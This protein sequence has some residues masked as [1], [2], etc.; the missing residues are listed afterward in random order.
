MGGLDTGPWTSSCSAEG[1]YL[2]V[3]FQKHLE[4]SPL[5]LRDMSL[6]P[7]CL[8]NIKAVISFFLREWRMLNKK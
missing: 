8:L 4:H 5:G 6:L 1:H 7:G 3:F 2:V